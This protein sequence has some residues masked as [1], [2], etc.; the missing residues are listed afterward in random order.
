MKCHKCKKDN[1]LKAKYCQKCG[2]KFTDKEREEAYNKTFFGKIDSFL[3]IKSIVTL[4]VITGNIFF[5][6]G[7]LLVVL[8]IG[9]YFLLTMGIHTK[10]LNSKEYQVI[11]NKKTSEYYLVV[12][13]NKDSIE[14]NLYRPNRTKKMV[15]YTYD[16]E[17]KEVSKTKVS[18]KDKIT[19]TTYQDDYHVIESKYSNKKKDQLKVYVYHKSD[20]ANNK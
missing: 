17:D 14:L 6:I 9:I 10:I 15:V 1:I 2:E 20:I 8:G 13:D 19:L 11:Y 4:N 3:K 18:K 16:L 7:S 12:E 5:K